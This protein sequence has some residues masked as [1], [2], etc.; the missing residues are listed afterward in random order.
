[1]TLFRVAQESL[2]NVRRH[3]QAGHVW[4]SIR[5]EPAEVAIS[6]HDDGVGFTAPHH[7]TDIPPNGHFGLLGMYERAALIDAALTIDSRPG[8]G[9]R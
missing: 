8:K 5:F 9:T 1:M 4:V 7:V 6:V 2:N 3:S